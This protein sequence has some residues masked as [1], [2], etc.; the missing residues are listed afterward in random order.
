MFQL[1][2]EDLKKRKIVLI[3]IAEDTPNMRRS[4]VFGRG[5]LGPNW[6]ENTKPIMTAYKL[7]LIDLPFFGIQNILEAA[8]ERCVCCVCIVCYDA[9]GAMQWMAEAYRDVWRHAD[10]WGRLSM[11]HIK[12][13]WL[14]PAEYSRIQL[15]TL[16][17]MFMLYQQVQIRHYNE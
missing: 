7:V 13:S 5:P 8:A 14:I 16:Y 10:D 15:N 9:S 17:V 4:V 11:S 3:N 6:T 2:L 1:G 12:R